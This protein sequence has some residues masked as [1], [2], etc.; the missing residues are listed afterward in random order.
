[1]LFNVPYNLKAYGIV[2]G[3]QHRK[4]QFSW[5]YVYVEGWWLVR[6]KRSLKCGASGLNHLETMGVING[7]HPSFH[8]LIMKIVKDEMGTMVW[9]LLREIG[10]NS[11]R[12]NDNV[13][14]H[15]FRR[16]QL[17]SESPC[18]LLI[19]IQNNLELVPF[20]IPSRKK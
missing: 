4:Y 14:L 15:S 8:A 2:Y 11:L 18:K 19:N 3:K 9:T 6:M 10:G 13:F 17:L 16:P 20:L 1:M 5:S 12:A 7:R